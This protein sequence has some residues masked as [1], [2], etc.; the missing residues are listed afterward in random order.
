M[1]VDTHTHP[2]LDEYMPDKTESVR[3][4]I[5]SGV[6]MMV[7]PNVDKTTIGPMKALHEAFPSNT[8]MAMGL[9]PTEIR[10]NW[11][12]DLADIEREL[13]SG[14]GYHAV[15]EV[16][17]DLYWDASFRNEQM[18]ALD[19]QLNWAWQLDLPVIIHCRNGLDEILDIFRA[20]M[21]RLPRIVFHSFGGDADD[22]NRI[23]AFCDPWFGINGI[24]TFKNSTLRNELRHIG[25]DRLL[26]E[27]DAPY[28]APVPHRGRRNES[29]YIM[30]TARHIADTL[31]LPVEQLENMTSSNAAQFFNITL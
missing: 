4:A 18:A 7:M 30:H 15:G 6:S 26:L 27:T 14:T 22:I 13:R 12:N 17:I 28:L 23:R 9:H 3:R 2:Y 24:V 20:H 16:G 11:E 21:G 31:G 29:A 19:T 8:I 5:A 25:I 10:Q 1:I